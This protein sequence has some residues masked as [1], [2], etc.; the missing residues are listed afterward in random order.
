MQ[1]K[2]RM[3]KKFHDLSLRLKD[4]VLALS[5]DPHGNALALAWGT[6][7]SVIPGI[8]AA[9]VVLLA[10]WVRRERRLAFISSVTI[11]NFY[12]IPPFYLASYRLGCW[13]MGVKPMKARTLLHR[14]E[15][16]L[17]MD[18]RDF[19][20][21]LDYLTPFGVGLAICGFLLTVLVYTVAFPELRAWQ[22]RRIRKGAI[23]RPVPLV[24][25]GG[26]L[27]QAED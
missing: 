19:Q 20:F 11:L 6:L 8:G 18:T 5:E 21:F 15:P 27:E 9:V 4:M 7:I 22:R 3:K 24:A 2:E 13:L 10:G 14:L 25:Q 1:L 16:Q 12:T 23:R 17:L 26:G